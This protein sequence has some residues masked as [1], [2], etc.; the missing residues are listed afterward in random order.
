MKQVLSQIIMMIKEKRP[1]KSTR[2]WFC[3]HQPPESVLT[4]LTEAAQ[5]LSVSWAGACGGD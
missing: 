3:S 2:T 1:E 5:L 4:V